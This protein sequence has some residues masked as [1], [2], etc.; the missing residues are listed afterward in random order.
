MKNKKR[1]VIKVGT[2]ILIDKNEI[3]EKN[4]E[5]IA[6]SFSNIKDFDVLIVSSGA[7]TFGRRE[8]KLKI[9]HEDDILRNICATVGQPLLIKKYLEYF[10]KKDVKIGQILLT[11]N[12]L[13]NRESF[14]NAKIVLENMIKNKVLPIINENDAIK[15][16][17]NKFKDNDDLAINI[18][19]KIEADLLIILTNVDGVYTKDP[20]KFS[21]AELVCEMNSSDMKNIEIGKKND[22][23]SLGGMGSK[24]N[25]ALLSSKIGINT[26][27]AN[28]NE[29]NIIGKILEGVRLGTYFT[30]HDKVTGKKRWV[31]LTDAKGVIIIDDGAYDALKKKKSLL[32]AGVKDVKGNFLIGE[33][34]SIECDGK[35]IGKTITDLTSD[36]LRLIK[37]KNTKDALKLVKNYDCVSKQINTILMDETCE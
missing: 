30:S 3:K 9:K 22:A 14:L 23:S 35:I 29:D 16:N 8:L 36:T 19:S 26:V 5:N 32:S 25:S 17:N 1:V 15:S 11:S 12:D 6:N 7:V 28:G 2:N 27:I 10:S 24:I 34:V 37:G 21:E 13:S 18:A 4:F 33:V 20:K 31:R